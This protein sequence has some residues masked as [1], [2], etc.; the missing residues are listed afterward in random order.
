MVA[1]NANF[2]R[3]FCTKYPT[4]EV[5]KQNCWIDS[6]DLA[7]IALPRLTSHRLLDLVRAFGGPDSTHRADDDVAATCLVYRV[8]LA[9]VDTMPA[10]LLQHIADMCDSDTWNTERVFKCLAAMKESEGPYSLRSSRKAAVA[11]ASAPLRPD[12]NV[13]DSSPVGKELP[14]A[15]SEAPELSFATD[16]EI[17]EAFSVEGLLGSLY[18]EYE[19]REE[20]REMAF[21]VNRALATSRNLAVEAGT[22][23]GKSMAYLVPLA[24]A[25]QKNGITVGVATK[26][27]ALLDQLV[28]KELPLLSKALGIT[29]APLKGFSHYPCLRKVDSLVNQGPSVIHYRKQEI[30]QAPAL[31]GLLLSLIHI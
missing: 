3:T 4:G 8:L 29:Y 27:N 21:A 10:P 5:L 1:H 18:E 7:K 26:T 16:A 15:G 11:Q 31:A 17:S 24:L 23:V 2:D 13:P 25:A 12:V 14:P 9:A 20:Q 28:H 30:N 22:G 6:L 19:P